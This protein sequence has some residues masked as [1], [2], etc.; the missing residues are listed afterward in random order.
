MKDLVRGAAKERP[1]SDITTE[2]FSAFVKDLLVARYCLA[3]Q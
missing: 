2:A 1:D 3:N